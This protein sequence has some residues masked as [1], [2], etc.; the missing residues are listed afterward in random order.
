M[1]DILHHSGLNPKEKKKIEDEQE[2]LRTINAMFGKEK[3]ELLK[4]LKEQDQLIADLRKMI[5]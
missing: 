4:T 3:K 2:A 5:E 1:T